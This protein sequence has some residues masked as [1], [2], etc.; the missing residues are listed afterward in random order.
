M[1]G[2][3]IRQLGKLPEKERIDRFTQLLIL[4]GLRKAERLVVEEAKPMSLEINLMENEV[5]RDLFLFREKRGEERGEKR[6]EKLGHAKLLRLQLEQ[7]FGD[8]PKWAL[9]LLEKADIKTLEN[10]GLKL[11]GAE[12]LEAVLPKPRSNRRS[13]SALKKRNGNKKRNGAK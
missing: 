3:I 2:R 4:S 8:L 6:G 11:L 5:F 9:S 7:R 10:W 1:T 12:R 13:L